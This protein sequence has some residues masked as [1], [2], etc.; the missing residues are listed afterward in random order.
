MAEMVGF[1]A[2]FLTTIAPFLQVLKT[3]RTRSTQDLSWGMWTSQMTGNALW[4]TYG[5]A[6]TSW[7]VMITNT[8]NVLC[9]VIL[10]TM[11]VAN[12][13]QQGSAS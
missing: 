6:I 10:L 11:M 2:G 8:L 9:A 13:R 4:F 5:W 1:L 12:R 3:A 7:P